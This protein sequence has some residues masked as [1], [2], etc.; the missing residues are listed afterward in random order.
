MIL[1][2]VLLIS[3]IDLVIICLVLVKSALSCLLYL[4]QWSEMRRFDLA[5]LM[6][7]VLRAQLH[8]YD[9][10][11]SMALRYL[12][13]LGYLSTFFFFG[14]VECLVIVQTMQLFFCHWFV[15]GFII[16]YLFFFFQ[17]FY[18]SVVF[19]LSFVQHTQGILLTSRYYIT[20]L[21]SDWKIA[22]RGAR[23]SCHTTGHF[24]WIATIWWGELSM[25]TVGS[26]TS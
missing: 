10:I 26:K 15:A 11:F 18:F 20:N 25:L 23:S 4:L 1:G 5:G 2:T 21:R 7:S 13:R 24:I 9:P 22:S 8:A 3:F 16:V 12:I 17:T 19:F 14:V 6:S